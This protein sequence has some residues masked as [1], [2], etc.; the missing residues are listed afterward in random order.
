MPE[1][2]Q[3]R[4]RYHWLS[5]ALEAEGAIVLTASRRLAR[6]L[7][8]AHSDQQVAAGKTAWATPAIDFVRDWATRQLE[9]ADTEDSGHL[10]TTSGSAVIWERCVRRHADEAMLGDTALARLAAA[11]WRTV[12]DW[13]IPM[14]A[15]VRSARTRDERVFAAAADDYRRVLETDGW[16]DEATVPA[17]VLQRFER[18]ELALTGPVTLVGFDRLAPVFSELV[19]ALRNA[20]VEVTVRSA[21]QH[22]HSR[23]SV[24]LADESA[25]LRAAG[26]WA[27]DRLTREPNSNTAIVVSELERD[28]PRVLRLVREGFAPGWQLAGETYAATVDISYGRTLRDYPAVSVAFLCL[29]AVTDGIE[30]DAAG[31]LLLSPFLLGGGTPERARLEQQLR[32]IPVRKWSPADLHAFLRPMQEAE[33]E[34][35]AESLELLALLSPWHPRRH[36]TDLPSLWARAIDELLQSA[37]WPGSEVLGSRDF[38]L[39]DRWREL[40]NE[41]ARLDGVTGPLSFRSAVRR[42]SMLAGETLFRPETPEARVRILGPLETAGMEFDAV[43]MARCDAARWPDVARP[44]PLLS[45]SLQREYG[46]PDAVPADSLEHAT[47]VLSRIASSAP[48][49]VFSW[50]RS[51]GDEPRAPSPL[52]LSLDVQ[53][54]TEGIDPGWFAASLAGS[55]P[56]VP[57]PADPVPEVSD[58]EAVVGGANTLRL[59]ETEP[60]QA[61]ARGRLG[62]RDLERFPAGLTPAMRG[63]LLHDAL[64][65]LYAAMPAQVDIAAWSQAEREQRVRKAV[66]RATAPMR[67]AAD[68]VLQRLL[69]IEGR[70]MA[71]LLHDVIDY[72]LER[73]PFAIAIIEERLEYRRSGV[74]LRL[75]ADRVDRLSDGSVMIIDYKTGRARSL[76]TRDGDP[77]DPQ[78][79]LY[80]AAMADQPDVRIGGLALMNVNSTSVAIK[81]VGVASESSPMEEAD[82]QSMLS[83]WTRDVEAATDSF[84]AGDVAV[85]LSLHTKRP[86]QLNVLCRAQELLHD[87]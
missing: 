44:S 71:G 77:L 15:I 38:Q 54:S 46:V 11:T 80:A 37:G 76:L 59:Q 67:R 29:D 28:A 5:S 50:P 60:F 56:A 23:R 75:R 6:E 74:R 63:T 33:A 43:W 72:D 55:S 42:L 36:E 61:F 66:T 8:S 86:W 45:R 30:S 31:R 21:A 58:E 39:V 32:T 22:G 41:L 69:D 57:V 40:L 14:E 70:R 73:Q 34:A 62:I 9:R 65:S 2:A 35:T 47:R 10:L 85:N 79:P 4:R 26:R 82:W 18:G 81:S 27:A 78:V 19:E 13:R 84:A 51:A 68:E 53:D 83:R 64:E 17:A 1:A 12:N 49:V 87:A 16:L 52:L 20:G 7:R 25:E 48:E 24:V 3:T